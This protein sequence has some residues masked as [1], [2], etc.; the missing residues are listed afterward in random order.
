M[1]LWFV[2]LLSFKSVHAEVFINEVQV[3]P[4][5]G[6][7]I[8]LF[9]SG[10][11]S[12]NLT[13]WYIQRKTTTGTFGSLVTKTDFE[14]KTIEPNSYFLISRSSLSNSNIV[15]GDMTL[16][17]SNTI[18]LKNSDGNVADKVG[19][20]SVTD[21][22]S[23]CA[24]NPSENKSIGRSFGSWIA[25]SPTPGAQNYTNASLQLSGSVSND[26]GLASNSLVLNTNETKTKVAETPKIKTKIITKILAFVNTPIEFKANTT[27]YS[28]ESLFYGKYFWNFGD[29]DSKE[30]RLDNLEKIY[31]TFF[32]E[33]EYIVNLEYYQNYYSDFPDAF[34]KVIIKVIKANVSISNVGDDKDFF[35]EITNNT[36]YDVDI[37]KWVLLS[38]MRSFTFPKN[39]ILESKKKI[40]LSP[41]ITNFSIAD[42]NNLK[43]INLQGETVFDY[44]E[45]VM[46]IKALAKNTASKI[47][48]LSSDQSNLT[49]KL[50][51]GSFA[52]KSE[53]NQI[54]VSNS[55]V[56]NIQN[57][58]N[59]KNKF[60]YLI[61]LFVFLG[62]SAS[63]AYFVRNHNR[64]NILPK[65][66]DDFEIIDE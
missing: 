57:D 52:I 43:L 65:I 4:P 40:V 50:L 38:E 60:L 21:C 16:T 53:D 61:G 9:N 6:R 55:E 26:L 42:K 31:H 39:M 15:I 33:G 18:Q 14:N 59:T 2:F 27:G 35:V 13:D 34:D 20:G 1:F 64:K 19:W 11:S 12:V 10:T 41:K 47:S 28:N 5:E 36:N 7:F 45:S 44:Q 17:E 46:P 30:M 23:I 22:G 32:Y 51:E 3:S 29:G 49:A 63:G 54:A 25:G 8:E 62:I 56:E 66:G 48:T 58:L 37:S 24:P